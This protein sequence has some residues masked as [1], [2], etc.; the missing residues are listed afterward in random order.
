MAGGGRR[1]H[2]LEGRSLQ[3]SG[4]LG[5]LPGVAL[6][7]DPA[8]H[9]PD[10]LEN[11]VAAQ[12]AEIDKLAKDN[13][14]L[15]ASNAALREDLLAVQKEAQQLK[16]HIRSIQTESEIQIRV[17]LEKIAK[18]DAADIR[19][20]ENVKEDLKQALTEARNL[21]KD[22]PELLDK[23]RQASRELQMARAEVKGLP[24]L[25][26]ELD[27]LRQEYN[28]LRDSFKY[29]KG[30]NIAKVEELRSTEK[31]LIEM[32]RQVDTLYAEILNTDKRANAATLAAVA[33][34]GAGGSY[35]DPYGRSLVHQSS[36]A[37][38]DG[39][40]SNGNCSDAGAATR[41]YD[42][43]SLGKK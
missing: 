40:M 41:Q 33:L 39:M 3:T 43:P 37:A 9:H 13:R 6:V 21:V 29:E 23:M 24:D 1:P 34:H 22:R 26:A 27:D 15:V 42:D 31:N 17:L 14:L 30:F 11:K 20:A 8:S 2:T 10:R 12:A 38:G 16:A 5:P 7:L 19:A 36:A 28:R 25:Q 35:V 4:I 32:A 18:R